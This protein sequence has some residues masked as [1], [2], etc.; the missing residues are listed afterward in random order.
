MGE[1][2]GLGKVMFNSYVLPKCKLNVLKRSFIN[3]CL[4]TFYLLFVYMF[5]IHV[6]CMISIKYDDYDDDE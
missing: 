6:C 3:W 2:W 5:F 1:M 4:F